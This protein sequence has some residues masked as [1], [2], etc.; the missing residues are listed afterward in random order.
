MNSTYIS[1]FRRRSAFNSHEKRSSLTLSDLH[2]RFNSNSFRM[3]RIQRF[4]SADDLHQRFQS[5]Q[6]YFTFFDSAFDSS[7]AS[8]RSFRSLSSKSFSLKKLSMRLPNIQI[9]DDSKS[10]VFL[11]WK[12]KMLNKLRYN[13][14]HFTKTIDEDR[15]GFKITYIISRLGEEANTQTMWR[16]QYKSYSSTTKLLNYLTDLYEI[17]SKIA[18]DMC[19]QKFNKV[20]QASKQS[21][22]D[23]YRTFVKYWVF[24]KNENDLMHEMKKKRSIQRFAKCFFSYLRIS[25]RCQPWR[26]D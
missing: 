11:D 12:F 2:A 23:F 14:N 21:F 7:S 10:D 20:K 4:L 17:H 9:F 8:P 13:A 3:S 24:P 25:P 15:E 1:S 16:S 6:A 22:D 26:N 19:R 18:K 5:K